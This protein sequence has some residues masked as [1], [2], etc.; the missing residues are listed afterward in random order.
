MLTTTPHSHTLFPRQ[1]LN[2]TGPLIALVLGI[3]GVLGQ[4][5]ARAQQMRVVPFVVPA[6][7]NVELRCEAGAAWYVI[8]LLN[9][10]A[11]LATTGRQADGYVEVKYPAGTPVVVKAQE[12]QPDA[13]AG[14]VTLVR[15]SRLRAYSKANP[16]LEECFQPVFD[17]F[18]APGVTMRIIRPIR[19]LSG[20]EAGYIVEAP[21]GAKGFILARDLREATPDEIP[22]AA[23]AHATKP[24]RNPPTTSASTPSPTPVP[25]ARRDQPRPTQSHLQASSTPAPA[26]ISTPD[27]TPVESA[28]VHAFPEPRT[29]RPAPQGSPTLRALEAIFNRMRRQ[30]VEAT[31]E[32]ELIEQYQRYASAQRNKGATDRSL[33]FVD[34]RIA[35]LKLRQEL[36]DTAY[37]IAQL[38]GDVGGID[39]SYKLTIERLSQGR[40]YQ[41]V[42]RLLPSALYDGDTLP[43]LYRLASIDPTSPRTIA[44]ITPEPELNL[45]SKTG[46]IVGVMGAGNQETTGEIPF[47]NPSVVDV[48]RPAASESTTAKVES[49]VKE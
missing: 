27:P 25:T 33:Q 44:Y 7:Q 18:L 48:L 29:T 5:P 6:T 8:S 32:S 4:A 24:K 37:A 31:D 43:L 21:P 28:P 38:A 14:T 40:E 34:Q 35:V 30:P 39:N 20:Q 9:P 10:Q 23:R 45:D 11:V 16:V 15:R 49:P 22:S 41:A 36:R 46:A 26:P 12:V 1:I 2:Q 42:G 13:A 19:N 3:V 47:V 17:D